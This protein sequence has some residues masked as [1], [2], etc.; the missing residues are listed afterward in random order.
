MLTQ[1][2]TLV[3]VALMTSVVVASNFRPTGGVLGRG[4]YIYFADGPRI[5]RTT[6]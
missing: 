1:R 4:D 2:Y 5:L 6:K 3:Y